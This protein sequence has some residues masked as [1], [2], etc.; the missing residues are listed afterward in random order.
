MSRLTTVLNR[1]RKEA[2]PLLQEEVR[3]DLSQKI[4]LVFVKPKPEAPE[5]APEPRAPADP[6]P[7][8]KKSR[9]RRRRAPE[10]QETAPD[11]HAPPEEPGDW[12]WVELPGRGRPEGA[13]YWHDF[14]KG[15]PTAG[16]FTYTP[17]E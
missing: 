9:K 4:K 2:A 15:M 1:L 16:G 14:D 11:P 5:S 7:A 3:H 6:P 17:E 10:P 12:R 8:P 13:G